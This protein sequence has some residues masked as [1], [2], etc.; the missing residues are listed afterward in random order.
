MENAV[1]HPR[2][3]PA[4]ESE[5]QGCLRRLTEAIADPI[6]ASLLAA[7]YDP[8]T[9]YA[10]YSFVCPMMVENDTIEPDD[11]LA[12]TALDVRFRPRALRRLR[13]TSSEKY[14][15]TI[16]ALEAVPKSL[17]IAESSD[18][19]LDNA[20]AFR[21]AL[22]DLV[23]GQR[24]AVQKLSARKRPHLIP[25]VDSV[26]EEW[27][28]VDVKVGG[29]WKTLRD[30]L[31]SCQIRTGLRGLAYDVLHTHGVA[32]VDKVPDLRLF[33][34]LLWMRESDGASETRQ[35]LRG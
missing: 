26:I 24:V 32:D 12:I 29:Y 23:G 8:D 31:R 19:E 7:F 18:R 3:H 16:A 11:L 20:Y 1:R 33:D 25:I 22:D 17:P 10:G 30:I 35:R 2:L 13:D 9:N 5:V 4:N 27:L 34:S 14:R 21:C 6:A 15:G 28:N